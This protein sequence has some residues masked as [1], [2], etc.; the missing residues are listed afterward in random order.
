M[1][2]RW[3]TAPHRSGSGCPAAV[4]RAAVRQRDPPANTCSPPACTSLLKLSGCAAPAADSPGDRA[5]QNT[6]QNQKFPDSGS[7]ESPHRL[8][9]K[10][11]LGSALALPL[12][13]DC[14]HRSRPAPGR[15]PATFAKADLH[16]TPRRVLSR[17]LTLASV[18]P[19]V[20]ARSPLARQQVFAP[21]VRQTASGG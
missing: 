16:H 9:Q 12:C 15:N 19:I 4:L 21:L 17:D 1:S 8:V 10:G 18:F 2:F 5:S 20:G 6:E 13:S 11:F 7:R 14:A 3:S